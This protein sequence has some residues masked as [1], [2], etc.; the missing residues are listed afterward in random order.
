VKE[1][2]SAALDGLVERVKQDRSVLAVILC[3]SLSHDTVW[4][5]SDIDL[6]LVTVDERKL[7][8][9]GISLYADGINVHANLVPRAEFRKTA[10]GA[11]RNSFWHSLLAKGRLVYT[12]DETIRALCEQLLIVGERDTQ[13]QL[14]SAAAWA[15]PSI[16]K[17]HKWFLTRGD[18]DLTALWILY[19]ANSLAKIEVLEA[20]RLVD[21]ESLPVA[22]ELNPKFFRTVYTEMLNAKKTRASVGKALAA[23]DGYLAEREEKIFAPVVEHLREVG[24]AR[25]ATEIEDHFKRNFG[26]P[27]IT[28]VLEYL[29][30]RGI[31][32][33]AGMPV[34][35]TKNSSVQVEELGFFYVGEAEDE[36]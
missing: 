32:G 29:A 19:A 27:G 8:A 26:V 1:K 6:V 10:E 5:K 23:I 34:K 30:D 9:E 2:F 17:A 33:K 18:L 25:S 13:L 14:L 4:E 35:L 28:G 3:G 11:I 7:S 20:R 15:L 36:W 16:Y 24:E 31:L 21:R 12:H 22:L